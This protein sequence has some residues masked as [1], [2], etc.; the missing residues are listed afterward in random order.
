MKKQ[1]KLLSHVSEI[2]VQFSELFLLPDKNR[3]ENCCL[4]EE[5]ENSFAARNH[6]VANFSRSGLDSKSH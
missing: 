5:G 4:G 1:K 3:R 6:L 2:K